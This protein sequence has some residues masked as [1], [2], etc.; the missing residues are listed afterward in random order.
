MTNGIWAG[1]TPP[2]PWPIREEHRKRAT[3]NELSSRVWETGTAA[4]PA[5]RGV[6]GRM[7][8]GVDRGVSPLGGVGVAQEDSRVA[9]GGS[10]RQSVALVGSGHESCLRPS[11]SPNEIDW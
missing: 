7:H 11:D 4:D 3:G 2:S 1:I 5:E 6:S 10:R 8:R 9:R